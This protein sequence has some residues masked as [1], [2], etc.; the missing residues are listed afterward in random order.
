M[1]LLSKYEY[2]E[3]L[4]PILMFVLYTRN[5]KLKDKRTALQGE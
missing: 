3:T 4:K 1:N 5:Y 2:L